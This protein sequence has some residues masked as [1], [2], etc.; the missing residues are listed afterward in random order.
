MATVTVG[1]SNHQAYLSTDFGL[2]LAMKKTGMTELELEALVGRYKKG[3]RKGKLKGMIHWY[4]VTRGG[5]FKTGRYDF[6]AMQGSGFVVRYVGMCFAF[7]IS[8]QPFRGP[9]E[10]LWGSAY[11]GDIGQDL[12]MA[13]AK[14]QKEIE[15]YKSSQATSRQQA[16][17][18]QEA[19]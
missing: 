15:D 17:D 11:D 9:M 18:T 6:D 2:E 13:C 12:G 3:V 4:K 7:G 8:I 1:F 19:V 14:K 16:D 5:W 10:C